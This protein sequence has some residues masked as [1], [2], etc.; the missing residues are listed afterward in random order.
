M[1]VPL[2]QCLKTE[3]LIFRCHKDKGRDWKL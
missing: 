1:K 3:L 2:K